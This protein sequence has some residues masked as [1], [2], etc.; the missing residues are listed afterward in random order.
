MAK[1]KS[2]GLDTLVDALVAIGAINWGLV[3]VDPSYDLIKVL[4]GSMPSVTQ[5]TYVLI[6]LAGLWF[7][8]KKL[9]S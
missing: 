3:G 1:K 5:A 7:G 2:N 6:G 4:L 8:Y 9:S